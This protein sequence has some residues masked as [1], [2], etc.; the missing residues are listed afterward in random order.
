M[1]ECYALSVTKSHSVLVTLYD[2]KRIYEYRADG[3]VIKMICVSIENLTHCIQSSNDNDIFVVS[4]CNKKTTK[5]QVCIID[6]DG[7][8]LHSHHLNVS[9]LPDHLKMTLDSHGHVIV[10]DFVNHTVQLLSPTLTHLGYIQIPGHQIKYPNALHFD[11]LNHRLYIGQMS[12]ECLFVL[13]AGVSVS[14]NTGAAQ[15]IHNQLS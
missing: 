7:Q 11:E 13:E 14:N 4:R 15:G 2:C 10:T 8:I 1:G 12:S 5:S 3:R 9:G 6:T